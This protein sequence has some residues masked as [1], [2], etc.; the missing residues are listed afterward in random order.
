MGPGP[1]DEGSEGARQ[2]VSREHM[3]QWGYEEEAHEMCKQLTNRVCLMGMFGEE[4]LS[5]KEG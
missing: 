5:L 1:G 2:R 3:E 4:G